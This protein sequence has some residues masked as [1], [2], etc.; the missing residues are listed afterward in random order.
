[1]LNTDHA[2]QNDAFESSTRVIENTVTA[3][4]YYLDMILEPSEVQR[5][6]T[7]TYLST[8]LLEKTYV[9]DG[10]TKID[11]TNGVVT[12]VNIL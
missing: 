4:Q 7:H 8:K 11:V 10:K 9:E 5:P 3:P 6:E 2:D 1:M 12:Q